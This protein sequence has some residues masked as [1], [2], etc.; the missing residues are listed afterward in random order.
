MRVLYV[1]PDGEFAGIVLRYLEEQSLA[2]DWAR[3]AQT[4]V[5]AADGKRPDLVVLELALAEHNGVAFLQEFRSYTD[6]ADIPVIIYS[7]VPAESTG[8]S[9]KDWQKQ[10]VATYLYKP[11]TRLEALLKIIKH[12]DQTV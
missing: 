8:L 10:G 9:H 5:S 12:Y 2:V 1:E 11:T 4:A 6:W 7:H 3:D